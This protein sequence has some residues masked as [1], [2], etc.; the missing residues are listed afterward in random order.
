MRTKALRSDVSMPEYIDAL[1][2]WDILLVDLAWVD[3]D[4]VL[5]VVDTVINLT[6][7]SFLN[8]MAILMVNLLVKYGKHFLVQESPCVLAIPES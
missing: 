1:R 5:Q 4:V 7:A 6:A 3:G 8:F 2:F